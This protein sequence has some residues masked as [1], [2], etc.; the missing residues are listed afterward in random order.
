MKYLPISIWDHNNRTI[1]LLFKVSHA[2][3]N[4]EGEAYE[5]ANKD[6]TFGLFITPSDLPERKLHFGFIDKNGTVFHVPKKYVKGYFLNPIAAERLAAPIDVST[7]E[8]KIAATEALLTLDPAYMVS[9]NDYI[10]DPGLTSN[11]GINRIPG[12]IEITPSRPLLFGSIAYSIE[13]IE[14]SDRSNDEFTRV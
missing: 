9:D 3:Y 12:A 4:T 7:V 10:E 6:W 5:V 8:G 14:S 2:L 1:S 13:T 11:E